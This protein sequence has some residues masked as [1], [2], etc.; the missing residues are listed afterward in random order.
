MYICTYM[1]HQRHCIGALNG[2]HIAQTASGSSGHLSTRLKDFQ[3]K[4]TTQSPE[5]TSKY[6]YAFRSKI[7]NHSNKRIRFKQLYKVA[8]PYGTFLDHKWLL[9]HL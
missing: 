3:S 5:S 8:D 4:Y 7:L 9:Y 2:K 6:R 1:H